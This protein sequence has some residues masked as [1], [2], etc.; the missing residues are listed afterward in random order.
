MRGK[1]KEFIKMKTDTDLFELNTG[2][3]KKFICNRKTGKWVLANETNNSVLE[4]ISVTIEKKCFSGT[5]MVVLNI[6]KI[7]NF[8]CI[9]CHVD[10]KDDSM[11]SLETGKKAIDRVLEL[12]ENNRHVVF[13]GSEPMTNFE[14]IKDLV[15]YA[16]KKIRFSMQSNCSLFNKENLEFL[17]N[18]EVNI[19]ISL[20]GTEIHQNKNRPYVGGNPTYEEV[21]KNLREIRNVQKG[22]SV[23]SVVTKHNVEDLEKI[24]DNFEKQRIDSVLFSPIIPSKETY[25]LCPNQK[26]FTEKMRNV[27]N[28]YIEKIIKKEETIKIRNLRDLLRT[29]FTERTTLNCVKCGGNDLHPLMGVDI[30]GAIYPCD[31]FWGKSEYKIGNIFDMSLKESFNHSN[32]FRVYR[33][34]NDVKECSVCDWKTFCGEGC[35]GGSVKEGNG[36]KGK[37][38]YCDYTKKILPHIAEKIPFLHEN[39]LI[40]KLIYNN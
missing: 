9:Y 38:Y 11:M 24:V 31:Y 4:E 14:L 28:R 26:I 18:N 27:I 22:V 6:S 39:H 13:H 29:F 5:S 16:K 1:N 33:D 3:S 25:N 15:L 40:G 30:D 35:P 36:I 34:I 10:S 2:S 19:G 37:N 7:C 20:D 32:N 17:Y 23:I 12:E 8:D 21:T